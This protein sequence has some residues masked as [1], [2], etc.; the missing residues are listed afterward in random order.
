MRGNCVAIDEA[1]SGVCYYFMRLPHSSLRLFA[2][3]IF[4]PHNNG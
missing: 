1:I 3:T 2:M 4:D